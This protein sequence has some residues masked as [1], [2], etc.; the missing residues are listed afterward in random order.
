MRRTC[1]LGAHSFPNI[2]ALEGRQ[3]T[4]PSEELLAVLSQDDVL[5]LSQT[6]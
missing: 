4:K 1:W 3:A 6:W 2:G 5:F